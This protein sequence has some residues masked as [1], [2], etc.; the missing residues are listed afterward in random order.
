[1]MTKTLIL[2]LV[3][4]FAVVSGAAEP[5]EI[6]PP[7]IQWQQTYGSSGPDEP[8]EV[9]QTS[10]GGFIIGGTSSSPNSGYGNRNVTGPLFI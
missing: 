8:N 10:D 1:M 2:L 6:C 9:R 4:G 3:A 7:R 5:G